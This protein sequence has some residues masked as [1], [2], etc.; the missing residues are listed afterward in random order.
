MSGTS[1]HDA[2]TCSW[3]LSAAI[4]RDLG[5]AVRGS[6]CTML[7]SD[8]RIVAWPGE[9]FVYADASVVCGP[10][11]LAEGTTDVLANPCVVFEVLSRS[12]EAYD[13]GDKWA[14]YRWISSLR[15]YVLASQARPRIELFRRER[16]GWRYEVVDAGGRITRGGG[17]ELELDGL[18]DGVFDLP[19]E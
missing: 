2:G 19:G 7:T 8:Q 11:E 15:E 1:E 9:H 18:Y 14:A 4:I 10:L 5:V 12:T 3:A 6:G 16:E 17:V 13:R